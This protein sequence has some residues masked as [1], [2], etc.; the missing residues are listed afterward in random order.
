MRPHFEM[1]WRFTFLAVILVVVTWSAHLANRQQKLADEERFRPRQQF[2]D[3]QRSLLRRQRLASLETVVS[4]DLKGQHLSDDDMK[5]IASFKDLQNLDLSGTDVRDDQLVFLKKLWSLQTL[6]LDNTKLTNAAIPHLGAIP[7]LTRLE[8]DGSDI[9]ALVIGDLQREDK[10][11]YT[12]GPNGA[13]QNRVASVQVP[14]DRFLLL[15]SGKLRL[16]LKFTKITD[17]G[18]GGA[19]YVCYWQPAP[20][21]PFESGS[22]RSTKGEVFEKYRYIPQM[23]GSRLAI[24]AGG[25]LGVD[26]G[27]IKLTWS[28]KTT[29]YL[30]RS[31]GAYEPSLEVALTNWSEP[32]EV[33]FQWKGLQWCRGPLLDYRNTA[34]F[35]S[36]PFFLGH[37]VRAP[38]KRFVLLR[39]GTDRMA[40]MLGR[41][42]QDGQ[43]GW[44]YICYW[45]PDAKAVFAAAK[46]L[47]KSEGK[48]FEKHRVIERTIRGERWEDAGSQLNVNCGP[49]Q[50]KWSDPNYLY[51]PEASVKS[52]ALEMAETTWTR[53]EEI[54]F[55]MKELKWYKRESVTK[56]R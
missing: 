14:V 2:D 55:D 13:L 42:I 15:R 26:C 34:A 1:V 32:K 41:C 25:K 44:A 16:A 33:D 28:S 5:T 47:K 11:H 23:D 27:P 54:A 50:L 22:L 6:H 37:L 51:F 7:N 45:Q 40:F 48:L 29:V 21:G 46:T 17:T 19:E 53:V 24:D 39:R 38:V 9:L 31:D 3:K 36:G 10:G 52:P 30:P 4:L 12:R 18:Q 8:V 49:L 56:R 43:D 20:E 35:S